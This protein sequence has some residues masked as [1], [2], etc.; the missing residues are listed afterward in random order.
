MKQIEKKISK[1]KCIQ[2]DIN[3]NSYLDFVATTAGKTKQKLMQLRKSKFKELFIH[4]LFPWS[5]QVY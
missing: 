5:L 4:H 1:K 2:K 3:I